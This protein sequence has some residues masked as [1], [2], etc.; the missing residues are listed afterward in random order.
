MQKRLFHGDLR[1]N[2]LLLTLNAILFMLCQKEAYFLG[3]FALALVWL[4]L[5]GR[6][7]TAAKF[8]LTYLLLYGL[9]RLTAGV[10]GLQTLWIFFN[11]GRHMLIPLAYTLG[12]ADAPT[13]SLLAVFSRLHLPKSLGISTVVLLRFA[14]TISDEVRAITNSLKFR[15]I[16]VG[17]WNTIAHLPEM[18]E[19]ILIPLLIRTTKIADELSA[20][21]MVRGV[22]IDNSITSFESLEFTISDWVITLV[23]GGL[24]IGICLAERF[25][26]LEVIR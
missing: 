10:R 20:A 8:L 23:F 17:V 19:R 9:S 18:F 6:A 22:R 24:S 16:G 14:P 26:L 4:L 15:G 21:A 3:L 2:F 5:Q 13:G 1:V 12:L 25:S 7:A 11:I